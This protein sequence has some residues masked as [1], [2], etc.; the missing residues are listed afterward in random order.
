MGI[1]WALFLPPGQSP[2]ESPHLAYAQS[3]AED[4]Q[5]PLPEEDDAVAM[6]STEQSLAR[7]HGNEHEGQLLGNPEWSEVEHDAWE[8]KEAALTDTERADGGGPNPAAGN[9]PLYYLYESL[10]YLAVGGDFFDRMYAMR[11]WSVLLLL[12][13]VA[14]TWLLVGELTGRNRLLQLTA[15]AVVGLWPMA[16]F[17]AS[18]VN[19]D[20]A[21][22]ALWAVAL[23][24]GVRLLR[25][26]WSWPDGLGLTLVTAAC[27]L[28]KPV[29]LALLPPVALVFGLT[30]YRAAGRDPR[31][32]WVLPSVIVACVLLAV[33]TAVGADRVVSPIS[34]GGLAVGDFLNYIW[35]FYL[36]WVGF[37]EP[38]E[39]IP[40]LG[41]WDIW[42]KTGWGAFGWLEVRFP[43][44]VY[45][46]FGVLSV[47]W[48]LV[49]TWAIVR[50]R[51]RIRPAEWAF[52]TLAAGSLLLGLHLAEWQAFDER[53]DLLLQ[54]R[55]L[56]P[57]LPLA[58]VW[59]A[60]IIALLPQ[61]MSRPAVGTLL[62]ALYVFQLFSLAVVGGRFYA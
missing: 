44:P 5:R 24:L 52:F 22:N 38:L 12:L 32:P 35:Q 55:Y 61:R 4:L 20:A 16:T 14:G 41:V 48:L 13:G 27:V 62:V 47:A 28:T 31:P 36:P 33:A 26:G 59:L 30:L 43:D 57:L 50:G 60:A 42:V 37:L 2:D 40:Q 3:I 6:F 21:V 49:G 15:G 56:F 18:S 53:G 51:I 9:P 23:W 34:E 19:P 46:V 58:A 7:H 45:V 54:G 29:G 39:G 1:A 10:P 25:R 17:I 8:T 11:L